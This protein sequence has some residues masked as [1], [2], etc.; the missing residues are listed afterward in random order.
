MDD[1]RSDNHSLAVFARKAGPNNCVPLTVP[2]FEKFQSGLENNL[3]RAE[4]LLTGESVIVHGACN[5]L[6]NILSWSGTKGDFLLV[7]NDTTKQGETFFD[8]QVQAIESVNLR[9]FDAVLIVPHFFS[10]VIELDYVRRGFNGRF[11]Y[12]VS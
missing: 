12:V 11:E 7:D 10:D 6:H 2:C 3:I 5:S 4:V 9:A 1:D 8:R